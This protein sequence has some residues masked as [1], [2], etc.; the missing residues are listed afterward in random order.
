MTSG[1]PS[2]GWRWRWNRKAEKDHLS[3]LPALA[4]LLT[5]CFFGGCFDGL[6][7]HNINKNDIIINIIII[8]LLS[9]SSGGALMACPVTEVM[10]DNEIHDNDNV[11]EN[12]D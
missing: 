3:P 7:G 12:E 4:Y 1:H 5:I 11:D 6:P 2:L 10:A 9:I 8:L